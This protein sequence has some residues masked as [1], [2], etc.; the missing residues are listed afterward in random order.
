MLVAEFI[1]WGMRAAC[2]A[3]CSGGYQ[4]PA[5]RGFIH[6]HIQCSVSSRKL[7]QM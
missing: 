6:H 7:C 1:V 5:C 4:P 3:V 2:C